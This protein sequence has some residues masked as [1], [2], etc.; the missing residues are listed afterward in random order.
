M[1]IHLTAASA[2]QV[3]EIRNLV[4]IAYR[5]DVGWTRETDI[6][7]GARTRS[8]EIRQYLENSNA[9]L[10][11]AT[12]DNGIRACICIEKKDNRAFF[13]LFAVH[14]DVQGKGMG[15]KILAQAE[16]YATATL[17]LQH[18][19]MVVISQRKELLAFYAR[20]GYI[21]TGETKPY[22]ADLN[23]GTP[24][25]EGLTIEYLEKK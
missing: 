1:T 14:P 8:D 10:L 25:R 18:F 20:R 15:G 23:L 9:H 3:E 5:G 19:V 21:K 12:T 11:V 6:V 4:N 2:S 24:L 22:P 13:G 7:K 16:E 17:G